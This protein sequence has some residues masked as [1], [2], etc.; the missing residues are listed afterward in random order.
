MGL[1]SKILS[2]FKMR[3]ICWRSSQDIRN[4]QRISADTSIKITSDVTSK[5]SGYSNFKYVQI[6][7]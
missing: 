3:G 4:M 1:V 5:I 6:R 7:Q 2:N